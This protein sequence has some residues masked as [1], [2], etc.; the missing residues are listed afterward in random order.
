MAQAFKA[1]HMTRRPAPNLCVP[2]KALRLQQ[3][4]GG[5]TG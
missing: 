1:G 5:K 4:R 2:V 3:H